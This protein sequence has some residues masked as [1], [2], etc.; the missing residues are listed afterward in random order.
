MNTRDA[1]K[2]AGISRQTLQ[3]WIAAGRI[4]A[5]PLKIV[6]GRARRDWRREDIERLSQLKIKIYR[7]GRGRKPRAKR[8]N[9]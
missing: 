9:P 6:S 8:G 2:Q 4:A 5:P 3:T 7:K 1:A